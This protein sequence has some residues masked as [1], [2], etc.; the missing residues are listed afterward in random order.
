MKRA[1]PRGLGRRRVEELLS[2]TRSER[3]SARRIDILSR[4][5][6]G[7]PYRPNPL[8]GS[9]EAA[10][11]FT[12]SLD[13]FDC[14]TYIET[15]LALALARNI[16]DV[17]GWL[18]RI[19]YERGVIEWS[20]RNHYMTSWIRNNARQGIVGRVPRPALLTL[21]KTRVLNVVRGLPARRIALKC[22]PKRA[23]AR[24][25]PYLR[26]GDLMFFVSTRGN[27]DVFHAGIIVRDGN[28]LLLRHASRSK[29]R[30]VE[31][32]LSEFLRANRMTGVIIVRPKGGM[33]RRPGG[34]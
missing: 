15:V 9:A 11:V 30:V 17:A 28:D 13:G 2:R 34:K 21:A 1:Q 31:Q 18:R 26:S 7:R 14:V 5:L 32:P 4:R 27:L 23:V 19:R 29:G 20:H 10:E 6:L 8:I 33:P 12:A 25:E 24:L 16:G 22:L 3:S